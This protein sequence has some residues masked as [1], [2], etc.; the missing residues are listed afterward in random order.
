MVDAGEPT[1]LLALPATLPLAFVAVVTGDVGQEIV[2]P[3]NQLLSEKIDEGDDRCFLTQL[4]EL[5]DQLPNAT[6]PLLTSPWNE[7]HVSLHMTCRLVVLAVRDLPAEV[8][9]EEGRVQYPTHGIV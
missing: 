1:I 3:A 6:S 4:A 9:H 2:R 5:V 7:D 8:R